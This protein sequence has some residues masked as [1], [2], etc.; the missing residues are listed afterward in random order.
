MYSHWLS[1]SWDILYFF[2]SFYFSFNLHLKGCWMQKD[3]DVQKSLWLQYCSLLCM[4]HFNAQAGKYQI[5]CT[6]CGLG[7]YWY[8]RLFQ[9]KRYSQASISIMFQI[10]CIH[11][12]LH[13]GNTNKSNCRREHKNGRQ[14]E[15]R[16]SVNASLGYL[17][18][19]P[20]ALGNHG[21]RVNV[22]RQ[23]YIILWWESRERWRE[24]GGWEKRCKRRRLFDASAP[25][26]NSLSS[27]QCRSAGDACSL[28]LTASLR[29][30]PTLCLTLAGSSTY[31]TTPTHP[32]QVLCMPEL[33]HM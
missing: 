9:I 16:W 23:N 18:V 1:N 3:L 22:Q 30:A 28:L 27:R 26:L 32:H 2:F 17:A 24:S 5:Q 11:I 15:F 29:A 6:P 25:T 33:K 10:F 19:T 20:L 8:S 14:T 12:E 21:N 7:I 4:K 13:V 31:H